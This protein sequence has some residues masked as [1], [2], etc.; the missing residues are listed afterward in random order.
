MIRLTKIHTYHCELEDVRVIDVEIH[1]YRYL[2]KSLYHR[3]MSYTEGIHYCSCLCITLL[4]AV[5][6]G[7]REDIDECMKAFVEERKQACSRGR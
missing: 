3:E 7:E 4:D 2:L 5:Q 1:Y 6:L